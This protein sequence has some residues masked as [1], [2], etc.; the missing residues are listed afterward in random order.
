MLQLAITAVTL[1]PRG[2]GRVRPAAIEVAVS[3]APVPCAD[4]S[5]GL[6]G[7]LK[8]VVRTLP[9]MPA[10][11]YEA[12][13]EKGLQSEGAMVRWAIT[14]VDEETVTAEIVLLPHAPPTR[15][16]PP[17]RA[18]PST[19]TLS[20]G[21]MRTSGAMLLACA[22]NVVAAAAVL[23]ENQRDEEEP[24]ALSA[25]GC[26]L[27]NAGRSCAAAADSLD[28]REWAAATEPLSDAAS[29]LAAAAASLRGHGCGAALAEAAA[30]L[31]DASSVTGCISLAAAAGPNLAACGEALS[32]ASLALGARAEG[33]E[34]GATAAHREAG[35]RLGEAS[36]CLREAGVAMAESGAN[37]EQGK[38]PL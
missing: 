8:L 1:M 11:L 5:V 32:A 37:L 26:E 28:E 4:A 6:S 18:A 24:G 9:L 38:R 34:V 30:E 23:G 35:A 3:R 10:H 29:S 27:G 36:A 15:A 14:A 19:M 25:G 21:W 2:S 16:A 22:D 20:D 17:P 31:E 13:L 7:R 12:E 33:L